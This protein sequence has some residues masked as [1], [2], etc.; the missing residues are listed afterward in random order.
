LDEQ[1]QLPARAYSYVV[2]SRLVKRAVQGPFREAVDALR[3]STGERIPLRSAQAILVDASADFAAFYEHRARPPARSGPILVAAIDCKGIPM[4]RTEP[5]PRVV[6]RGKGEKANKKKMATVAAVYTMEPR[7][8]TP[9]DVVGSLFDGE[10]APAR[11]G[12]Q[13]KRVW[14]SLLAG[15]DAFVKDMVAEV[16]RRDPRKRK[17]RVVVADGERALQLRMAKALPGAVLVL[18]LL[19]VLEKVWSA[20]YVFH[21]E[22]SPEAQAFAR[23]RALRILEGG[24]GQVVKGLRQMATKH[25]LRGPRRKTLLAAA[26]YLYRNRSRMQ[27]HQ[28]LARGLPIASGSVEGA[29]KNLV[30]DR[31]ERSGMRWSP[32]MAEAMLKMRAVYLSGHLD[33]YW[34]YHV[35]QEQRRLHRQGAWRPIRGRAKE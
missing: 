21:P 23:E 9:Q 1:L 31:M 3:E 29:C 4:V 27:Y 2:Q 26:G 33:G 30:K 25:G 24:V 18:D 28:Y 11:K 20:A 22:G 34:D 35:A 15:K 12:P 8:R 14:A 10:P 7:V 19:H 17:V 13:D 5:A 16:N 32:A 6:R